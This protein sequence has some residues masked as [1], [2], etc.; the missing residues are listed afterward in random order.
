M[1]YKFP[2]ISLIPA[3]YLQQVIGHCTQRLY[4]LIVSIWNREGL[5]Q[6]WKKLIIVPIFKVGDNI[7]C[8]NLCFCQV[9]A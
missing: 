8:S 2:S 6:Q 7:D 9:L 3:E 4:K 1:L 5:L